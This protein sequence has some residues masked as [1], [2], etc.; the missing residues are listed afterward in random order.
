MNGTLRKV[1]CHGPVIGNR[2]HHIFH[3][4]MESGLCRPYMS[5]H[6]GDILG[7]VPVDR[8]HQLSILLIACVV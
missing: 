8:R 7:D 6:N 2:I 5:S 4:R 1:K 3:T